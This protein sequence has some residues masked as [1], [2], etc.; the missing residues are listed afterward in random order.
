MNCI[1]LDNN[2]T[3][4]PDPK[5][6]DS[7]QKCHK[8]YFGNAS[9]KSHL[10]GEKAKYEFDEALKSVCSLINAEEDEIIFTSGATE[11]INTVL[12]GLAFQS[13]DTTK[14][15]ITVKTEHKATLE[16]CEYLEI[17]GIEVTYLTV[18]KNGLIDL[19][20]LEKAIQQNTILIAVML[21]NNETGVIQ[22]IKQISEIA[23]QNNIPVF[24]DATQA[25]GKIKVDVQDLG[26]DYMVFSAHKM[27]GTKG[28]GALFIK[29][30]NNLT[31]LIQ[32]GG[33]QNN[34]RG[35]TLNVAGIAGFGTACSIAESYLNAA[36]NNKV[37]LL[38]DFFEQQLSEKLNI[39]INCQAVQRLPNTS[40]I[41]HFGLDAS[42]F[43]AK[44]G[45]EL[46]VSTGSACS[47]A[48]IEPSHVLQ[49]MGL[50][51]NDA[52]ACIRYSLGRNTSKEEI[53]KTI[54]ILVKNLTNL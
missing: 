21:A 6:L 54:E 32:G 16:V 36:G 46:A 49:A 19:A 1:Y 28:V 42:T 37:K 34:F 29:K 15:I 30:G 53:K 31:P 27:Y 43:V 47:S 18:D 20:E 13:F 52:N 33:Q 22:P 26:I 41:I 2:A 50:S 17:L 14:H 44:I 3:T 48:I 39:Q 5:V 25:V 40:N 8:Y 24:T 38:R 10:Y 23:K 51:N 7:I 12:K 4:Q 45:D 35:G 9:S 11:G